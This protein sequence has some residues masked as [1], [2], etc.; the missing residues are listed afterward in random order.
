MQIKKN[1]CVMNLDLLIYINEICPFLQ[2]GL[3]SNGYDFRE[4]RSCFMWHL[5]SLTYSI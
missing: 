4:Y 3:P 1:Q 5:M 2:S